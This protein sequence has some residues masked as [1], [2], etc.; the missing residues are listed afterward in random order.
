MKKLDTWLAPYGL[1]NSYGLFAFMTTQRNEIVIEGSI[2]GQHWLPYEFKWKP[3]D[4]R[5]APRQ[6][7]PH[8]P[9]LD[10]QMW[11]AARR[12]VSRNPG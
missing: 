7:A 4:E 11:F 10:W 3:G 12:S 8:H 2:D 6:V 9:R 5:R 1:V